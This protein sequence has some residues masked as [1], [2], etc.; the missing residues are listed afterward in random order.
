MQQPPDKDFY[1][2]ADS[3]ILLANEQIAKAG[4]IPTNTSFM[5]SVARFNA[6]VV[7][8]GFKTSE[9]MQKAKEG[10]LEYFLNEYK[11]MLNDHLDDHIKNFDAYAKA[12]ESQE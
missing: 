1:N 2:R 3:H 10:A 7:A 5:Y 11:E 6:W 12:Q 4:Q 8:S 9:E